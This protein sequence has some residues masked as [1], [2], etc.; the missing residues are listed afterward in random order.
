MKKYL[1]IILIAF[2]LLGI[3]GC[4]NK[5]TEELTKEP[6]KES[7]AFKEEYEALNG[8]EN[9]SGKEHRKITISE[10]NPFEKISTEELIK[11]IDNKETLYVYFGDPLC[12]WCR[13]VLEKA[14]EVAEEKNISKI[15]YIKIWDEDGNEILR[16][17]YTLNK[18]NKPQLV[19]PATD[20]YY[21]LL[22]A[23]KDFLPDY[24]L[25]TSDGKE[26][27]IGEKRIFAPNFVYI[28]NGVAKKLVEG[29]SDK[30]TDSREELTKEI[31]EDEEK[32][33]TEFFTNK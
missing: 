15:Y 2:L 9:A 13:S 16:S 29:I 14:I 7:L 10:T 21:T 23:F 27:K 4:N 8:K 3:F 30:Q 22:K 6:T 32:I 12:P 31:L 1:R 17:K 5:K 25:K 11:K 28:E 18:K 20:D 33:F 24:T 19:S 26:I